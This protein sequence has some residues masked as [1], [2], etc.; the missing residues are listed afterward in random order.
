MAPR[1]HNTSGNALD[2]WCNPRAYLLCPECDGIGCDLC[3]DGLVEVDADNPD[4]ALVIVHQ[5][6]GGGA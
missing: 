2:C 3:E 1:P 4:E 5:E 6:E